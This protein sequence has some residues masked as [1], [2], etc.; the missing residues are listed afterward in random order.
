M[1][2]LIPKVHSVEFLLLANDSEEHFIVRFRKVVFHKGS[3]FLLVQQK[4]H[5]FFL[6][7]KSCGG[8][9]KL[10]G[11]DKE[12]YRELRTYFQGVGFHE[13]EGDEEYNVIGIEFNR[14][15]GHRRM[16]TEFRISDGRSLD[17]LPYVVQTGAEFVHFVE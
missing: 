10:V 14:V 13:Q 6:K 17:I 4:H 5:H 12:E 1:D 11:L 3:S 15:E 16:N 2:D 7:V 9:C 8:T